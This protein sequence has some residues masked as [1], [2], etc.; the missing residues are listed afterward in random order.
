MVQHY[1]N[2]GSILPKL[3]FNIIWTGVE[4]IFRMKLL[5]KNEKWK[6]KN[7]AWEHSTRP[8]W[9]E[10]A[11]K[12]WLKGY[13]LFFSYL[14]QKKVLKI[15]GSFLNHFWTILI[16]FC[17]FLIIFGNLSLF[18]RDFAYWR[19]ACWAKPCWVYTLGEVLDI[20]PLPRS[21]HLGS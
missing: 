7:N 20:S 17:T 13:F 18:V 12:S 21:T 16:H 9:G 2:F 15:L 19:S 3:W 6:I 10:L 11:R 14:S 5:K 4:P 1:Q 8:V